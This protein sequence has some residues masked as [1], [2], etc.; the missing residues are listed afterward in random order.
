[1]SV[2]PCPTQPEQCDFPVLADIGQCCGEQPCSVEI[3]YP[4]EAEGG[5]W[6][7]STCGGCGE[8]VYRGH[9]KHS[10]SKEPFASPTDG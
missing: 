5:C 8:P 9:P 2:I 4:C 10:S 6:D 3:Y 1:M 7:R